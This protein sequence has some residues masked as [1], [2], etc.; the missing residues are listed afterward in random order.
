[1]KRLPKLC[2]SFVC[3]YNN[4]KWPTQAVRKAVDDVLKAMTRSFGPD[5]VFQFY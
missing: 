2:L 5:L 3:Y 4:L 1:M